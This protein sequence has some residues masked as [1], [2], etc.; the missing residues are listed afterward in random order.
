MARPK[1]TIIHVNRHIIASNKKNNKRDPVLTVK[2]GKTN[3]YAKSVEILGPCRV[4]YSPDKPLNC[5]AQVWIECLGEVIT[6]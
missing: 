1:K 5:G 3:T 4:V 2:S 6:N